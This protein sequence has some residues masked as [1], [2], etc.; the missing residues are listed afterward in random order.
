MAHTDGGVHETKPRMGSCNAAMNNTESRISLLVIQEMSK[1]ARKYHSLR[2][3]ET[4]CL[5]QCYKRL[6]SG[7]SNYCS[8][9]AELVGNCGVQ[10]I[11]G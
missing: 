9:A 1:I 3:S 4:F 8:P 7:L 10:L 11:S 6:K 5:R 2:N